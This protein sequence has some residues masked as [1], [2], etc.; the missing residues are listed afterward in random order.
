[1]NVSYRRLMSND[2]PHWRDENYDD[3]W[4]ERAKKHRYV[5]EAEGDD[6][7]GDGDGG[8]G[9]GGSAGGGGGDGAGGGVGGGGDGAGGAGGG[10]EDEG[11]QSEIEE[12]NEK[13][14]S[15]PQDETV[16]E[17]TEGVPLEYTDYDPNKTEK[18]GNDEYEQVDMS[19]SRSI[20]SYFAVLL[21]IIFAISV[22][23]IVRRGW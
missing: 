15:A 3:L 23:L 11:E 17:A 18:S 22:H 10:S 2:Y 20:V 6:G 8:G 13:S 16:T 12:T 19:S 9:G 21:N 7:N 14:E 5:A 1:M 4:L